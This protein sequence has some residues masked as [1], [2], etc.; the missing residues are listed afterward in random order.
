M[1]KSLKLLVMAD[2]KFGDVNHDYKY[3]SDYFNE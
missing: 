2:Y 1:T 3:S